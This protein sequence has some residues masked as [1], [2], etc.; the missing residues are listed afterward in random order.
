MEAHL[1][2]DPLL[3]ISVV[4]VVCLQEHPMLLTQLTPMAKNH[5]HIQDAVDVGVLSQL[6]PKLLPL[7]PI[8][9]MLSKKEGDKVFFILILYL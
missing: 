4:P 5:T 8:E 2:P 9:V 7:L 1:D 3:K 6:L